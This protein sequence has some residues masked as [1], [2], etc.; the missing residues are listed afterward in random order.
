MSEIIKKKKT[1]EPAEISDSNMFNRLGFN[2]DAAVKALETTDR[3]YRERN[4]L[5]CSCGHPV[6]K[7]ITNKNTGAVLCKPG[8]L[9]CKCEYIHAVIEVPNTRFFM[10]KSLGNGPYHALSLGLV[11]A[12]K[13]AS[14][15]QAEQIKW[16]IPEMC[17]FCKAEGVPTSPTHVDK[18][19]RVWEEPQT[20]N[21]LICEDCVKAQL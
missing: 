10:R 2:P 19:K 8:L 5:I 20:H 16:V 7:H 13:G 1:A 18:A 12:I 17:E 21:V 15:E 6:A 3:S 4:G 11:A 9:H 14:K